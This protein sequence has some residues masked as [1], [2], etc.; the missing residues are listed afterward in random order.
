MTKLHAGA[1]LLS[2][3][4]MLTG[5]WNG[6]SVVNFGDHSLGDQLIDLKKALD[7]GAISETEFTQTKANLLE[8]VNQCENFE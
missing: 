5:C 3:T 4:F 6:H 8:M 7:E 2:T 1:L